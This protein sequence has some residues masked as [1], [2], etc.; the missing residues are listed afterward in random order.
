MTISEMSTE[1]L[2]KF[3]SLTKFTKGKFPGKFE[4]VYTTF[5]IKTLKRNK[6]YKKKCFSPKSEPN[7]AKLCL[8]VVLKHFGG[9]S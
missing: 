2:R 7:T 6:Y 9:N 8:S 4:F 5:L 1:I 3:V